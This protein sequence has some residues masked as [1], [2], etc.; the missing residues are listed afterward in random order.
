MQISAR[1]LVP[2]KVKEITEGVVNAEIVIEVAPGIEI[3]SVIT[4]HSAEAMNIKT[5]D[6]IKAMIK[7]SNVILVKD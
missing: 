2:G 6:P 5:G 1:N 7:A 4:K 3:V